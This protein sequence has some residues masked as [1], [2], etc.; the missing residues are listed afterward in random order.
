MT[1]TIT[2]TI[3]DWCLYIY[4][5]ELTKGIDIKLSINDK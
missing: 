1:I 5:H 2:M 3:V 4:L